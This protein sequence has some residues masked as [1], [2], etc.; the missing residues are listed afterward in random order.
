MDPE[1]RKEAVRNRLRS[2]LGK[3]PTSAKQE[4]LANA[5]QDPAKFL[6]KI[7]PDKLKQVMTMLQNS[8]SSQMLSE[9][10]GRMLQALQQKCDEQSMNTKRT[11]RR[12]KRKKKRNRKA[13]PAAQPSEPS[14]TTNSDGKQQQLIEQAPPKVDF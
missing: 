7:P 4:Q 12:R 13:P 5:L 3:E 14:A 2:K 10:D 9:N 8:E 1:S 6:Q 11:G